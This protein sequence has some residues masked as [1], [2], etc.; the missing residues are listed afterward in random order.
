MAKRPTKNN[1]FKN[2]S[3]DPFVKKAQ[4]L[5]YR[6]RAVFKLEEIDQRRKLFKQ[7]MVVVELGAAPGGWCQYVSQKIGSQGRLL[8][9]DLLPIDSLK[10]VTVIQGDVTDAAVF[11]DMVKWCDNHK[12]DAVISD[13]APDLTGIR[14]TDQARSA[15]LIEIA[16]DTAVNLL[17]PQGFLLYKGFQGSQF[18]E[19]VQFTK[20]QFKQITIEKPKASRDYSSEVYVLARN[21]K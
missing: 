18:Q 4:Q 17:K 16:I 12:V 11:K 10:Q 1:W 13:M 3:H 8:A 6:S 21:L 9:I 19:L 14:S 7:G 5:G 2:H 20:Q 15:Y